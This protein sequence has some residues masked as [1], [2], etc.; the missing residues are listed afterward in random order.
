MSAVFRTATI[1]L[2][3]GL[4]LSA[5]N[6]EKSAPATPGMLPS[7]TAAQDVGD[8][9][10]ETAVPANQL[11]VTART[12]ILPSADLKAKSNILVQMGEKLTFLGDST[13]VGE[14][15]KKE[16]LYH[17][18]LSD[19][20]EGW[21]RTYGI[22]FG[23]G[24]VVT[25]PSPL[26]QRPTVLSPAN[27][28]VAFGQLVG[29]TEEGPDGFVRVAASRWQAGWILKSSLSTERADVVAGALAGSAMA[30]KSGL[31]AIE[32]GL[33][34][35]PDRSSAIAIALQARLDSA[36]AAKLAAAAS[37]AESSTESDAGSSETSGEGTDTEAGSTEGE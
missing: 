20:T 32:A 28:H 37:D 27:K 19:G 11:V 4:V 7:D 2:A 6:K 21:A 35:L 29:M 15:K 17:V 24:A 9:T 3:A 34:A 10:S 14:G 13:E 33:A 22:I 12:V 26:Y 8:V 23:Q 5:C 30:K 18:K 31:A 16:F 25:M 36:N 1:S